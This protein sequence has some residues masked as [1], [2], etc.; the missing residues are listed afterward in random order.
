VNEYR[1]SRADEALISLG[2]TR[3]FTSLVRSAVARRNNS[4]TVATSVK[5]WLKF[6]RGARKDKCPRFHRQDYVLRNYISYWRREIL[7]FSACR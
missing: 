5:R 7:N 2:N 1:S 3:E 6:A 4:S